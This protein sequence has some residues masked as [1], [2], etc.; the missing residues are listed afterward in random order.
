[1]HRF[2]RILRRIPRQHRHGRGRRY[3]IRVAAEG[4]VHVAIDDARHQR[5]AA[6]VQ[7]FRTFAWR[8]IVT[9]RG[10]AATLDQHVHA[11]AC[12]GAGA[13]PQAGVAEQRLAGVGGHGTPPRLT[14][15]VAVP[16]SGRGAALPIVEAP[17]GVYYGRRGT[18][19]DDGWDV[20]GDGGRFRL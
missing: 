10:D 14:W 4:E 1:L 11:G 8:G 16:P 15:A 17:R 19:G 13:V 7:H 12:W 5:A 20:S 6:E 18:D 3:L 2:A 9:N